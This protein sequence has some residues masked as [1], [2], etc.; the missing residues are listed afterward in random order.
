MVVL[1]NIVFYEN[2]QRETPS[3]V[4]VMQQEACSR[5][6]MVK[7][8]FTANQSVCCGCSPNTNWFV[9]I[10]ALHPSI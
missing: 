4:T 8:L 9:I 1:L 7:L 2:Y 3:E 6:K 5:H 10:I